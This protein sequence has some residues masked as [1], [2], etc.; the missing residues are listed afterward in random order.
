MDEHKIFLTVARE[1]RQPQNDGFI[2]VISEGSPQRGAETTRV[3]TVEV[4][5]N[6]K[7]AEKWFRQ[8]LV[9]RPWEPRQ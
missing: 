9:E 8:M 1:K 3:L 6:M 5:Q 7:A 4:V 2:A